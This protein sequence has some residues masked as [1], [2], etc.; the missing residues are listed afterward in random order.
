MQVNSAL[1]ERFK[2][3]NIASID[4]K[5]M[6]HHNSIVIVLTRAYKW[7]HVLPFIFKEYIVQHLKHWINV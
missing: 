2:C 5:P 1:V 4:L 7:Y 3:E 6:Y